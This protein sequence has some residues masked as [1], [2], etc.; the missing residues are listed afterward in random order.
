MNCLASLTKYTSDIIYELII[1]DNGSD[2]NKIEE[3]LKRYPEIVPIINKENKGFGTA[4]N[5][6]LVIAKGKYVLIL[7]NDTMFFENTIK[8]VF[9]FAE[10]KKKPVIVGCKLLYRNDYVQH[11]GTV[12]GIQRH[13]GNYGGMFKNDDGYFAFPNI[14]RNC[15]AVTA[16]CMMIEKKLFEQIGGFD[17][18]LERSWQDVDLCIRIVEYRKLIV[19]TPYSMIYHFEGTTRGKTDSTDDELLA[20][21]IFREKHEKFI[22]NGDPYYNPN[23]SLWNPYK[24]RKNL[25]LN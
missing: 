12:I 3:K 25:L 15:S 21:K 23:L 2:E 19:Y 10:S 18:I 13:A 24:L 20:R 17:E 1:I 4:N 7:N 6:G 14:I 8:K 5:Q 22:R 11:A 9:D 16:A